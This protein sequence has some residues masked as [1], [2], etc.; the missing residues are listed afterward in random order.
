MGYEAFGV[1]LGRKIHGYRLLGQV[2]E[3]GS[4]VVFKARRLGRR[5]LKAI[6]VTPEDSYNNR[7]TSV[8]RMLDHPGIIKFYEMF[9]SR[10]LVFVVLEYC[11]GGDLLSW[12][13]RHVPNNDRIW[14]LLYEMASAISYLHNHGVAHGDIKLENF[15]VDSYG[16]V[17]LLDFGSCHFSHWVSTGDFSGTY[18][19][20]S[21][22]IFTADYYDPF[23]ADIYAF[24][25]SIICLAG[26]Y[27][28]FNINE[29]R[30]TLINNIVRGC[31]LWPKRMDSS[32][33]SVASILTSLDSS[34]RPSASEVLQDFDDDNWLLFENEQVNMDLPLGEQ[35]A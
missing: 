2:G 16:H 1:Q 18:P 28:P 31:F 17:K 34:K 15:G 24:G 20:A 7:E 6:K 4:S 23:K 35:L 32:L 11:R 12:C 27:F 10:G 25:I 30:S 19:Y 14:T 29:D 13:D 5:E 26:G 22:E 21:P 3:G 33:Q 8:L 9:R